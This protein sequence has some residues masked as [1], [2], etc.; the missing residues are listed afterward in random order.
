MLIEKIEI[1]NVCNPCKITY[2]T[3]FGVSRAF[4]SI[5]VKFTSG[6]FVGWGEAAAGGF[7]GFSPGIHLSGLYRVLL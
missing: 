5:V 2:K 6:D 4:D 3:S 7:P 1:F